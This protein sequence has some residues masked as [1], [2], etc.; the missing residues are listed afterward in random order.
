MPG[1][2]LLGEIRFSFDTNQNTKVYIQTEA[3]LL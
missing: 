3:I 1:I 2:P